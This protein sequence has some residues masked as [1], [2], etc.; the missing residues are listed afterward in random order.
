MTKSEWRMTKIN[1][2]FAIDF[3]YAACG[4][5]VLQGPTG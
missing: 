2:S 5:A 1:S 3:V 4:Y